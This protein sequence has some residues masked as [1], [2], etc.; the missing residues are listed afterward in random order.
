MS[1]NQTSPI[2][3]PFYPAEKRW[4]RISIPDQLED[5]AQI[6]SVVWSPE[7]PLTLIGGSSTIYT[8][9]KTN[10]SVKARFDL[11]NAIAG[12]RYT[13]TA[14]ITT[15]EGEEIKESVIFQVKALPT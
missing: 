15:S 4:A 1:T 9:S 5:G 3:G 12:T 13:I 14:T 8:R 10:D 7:S 2:R 11:L 6:S